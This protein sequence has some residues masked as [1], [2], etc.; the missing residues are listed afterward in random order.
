MALS[1]EEGIAALDRGL[2]VAESWLARCGDPLSAV[3]SAARLVGWGNVQQPGAVW[4]VC[5]HIKGDAHTFRL[6]AAET[7]A[8]EPPLDGDLE[9]GMT[10]VARDLGGMLPLPVGGS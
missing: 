10:I 5:F 2:R 3:G 7:T 9:S 8:S 4:K 1:S 6:S